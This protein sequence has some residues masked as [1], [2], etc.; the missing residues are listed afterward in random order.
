LTIS[1]DGSTLFSAGD[2]ARLIVWNLQTAEIAQEFNCSFNGPITCI[3]SFQLKDSEVV[4]FVFGCVDG[5]LHVYRQAGQAV[6]ALRIDIRVRSFMRFSSFMNFYHW[7]RPTKPPSRISRLIQTL[8]DWLA[9]VAVTFKFGLLG[10]TVSDSV[11]RIHAIHDITGVLTALIP[12]SPQL[13]Y[14]AWSVMF[15]D[16]GASVVFCYLESHQV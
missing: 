4:I 10:K 1:P 9:L 16:D 8:K 12:C 3:V 11:L 14:I 15:F 6:S 7:S 2:D 5:S 13:D